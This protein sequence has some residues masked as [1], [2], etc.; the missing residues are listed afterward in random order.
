MRQQL[1]QLLYGVSISSDLDSGNVELAERLILNAV[2]DGL[3]IGRAGIWLLNAENTAI[4]CRLLLDRENGKEIQMLVLPRDA[5]PAY[6]KALDTQRTITAEDAHTDP[7]TFEFS[8][9]YLKPLNIGAM[10]DAPIRY[11][12]K[13]I[14]IFCCEHIGGSRQWTEDECSFIGALADL[15]GRALSAQENERMN[16]ELERANLHLEQ[17]VAERTRTLEKTLSEL[18]AMQE[19]LIEAEK[20]ASL[21][22]LVAGIAH[23][24]NTPIGIAVTANSS[25]KDKLNSLNQLIEANT[26]T[27]AALLEGMNHLNECIKISFANLERA[28]KLISDF[29]QTAVDQS[30]LNLLETNIK[31]YFENILHSLMPLTRSNNVEVNIDCVDDFSLITVPGALSQI[32]LNLV[33]NSCVHG[34]IGREQNRIDITVSIDDDT[35]SYTVTYKDNGH[36]M[37]EDVMH[38][39]FE[40]F[41]TTKRG[42]GGSGLG[43][44]IVYNLATQA[45]QGEV[46]IDSMP[47]HGVTLIFK[48]PQKLA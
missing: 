24:V 12:G 48:L 29:K 33:N 10:L 42:S 28:A 16:A 44:S 20:M 25:A 15:Y 41:F 8:E 38:K 26:L 2:L 32:F 46:S 14:G 9:S 21:G 19:K 47:D 37:S 31:D 17:R 4:E 3:E 6:F 40:P 1:V 30:S 5:Y 35:H 39:V 23:E 34:F 11:K 13:M 45:L 43:M 36:G 7:A 27:K 18:T 22:N